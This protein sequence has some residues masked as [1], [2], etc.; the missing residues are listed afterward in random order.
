MGLRTTERR[1]IPGVLTRMGFRGLRANRLNRLPQ[2]IGLRVFGE[3]EGVNRAAVG[4]P[5]E[6]EQVWPFLIVPDASEMAGE[7]IAV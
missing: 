2:H 3:T 4:R 6:K 1:S 5:I 7:H